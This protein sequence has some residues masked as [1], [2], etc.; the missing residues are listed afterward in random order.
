MKTGRGKHGVAEICLVQEALPDRLSQYLPG[1]T[2]LL[3]FFGM[4]LSGPPGP[5]LE[6]ESDGD[7]EAQ[8]PLESEQA[9]HRW[10]EHENREC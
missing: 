9:K 8:E 1:R 3:V 5:D 2:S 4:D 7:V 6:E 10:E